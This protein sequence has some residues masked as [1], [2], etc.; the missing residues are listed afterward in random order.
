MSALLKSL[1]TLFASLFLAFAVATAGGVVTATP[2]EAGIV[3][4]IKSAAKTVG[5]GVATGAKAVGTAGERVGRGFARDAKAIA[6][7]KVGKAVIRVGKEVVKGA[8]R[9]VTVIKPIVLPKRR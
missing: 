3:S 9:V 4:S 7:S 1:T 6:N 2:S 5:R 8:D